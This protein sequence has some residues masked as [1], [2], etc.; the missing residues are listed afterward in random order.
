MLMTHF[1]FKVAVF[2]GFH[3][4]LRPNVNIAHVKLAL[5][6][7]QC[8]VKRIVGVVYSEVQLLEYV[9]CATKC[10]CIT[11]TSQIGIDCCFSFPKNGLVVGK[12]HKVGNN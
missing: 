9:L 6:R 12:H 7:L 2:I 5:R 11:E 8:V 4:A 10:L 1:K 3:R